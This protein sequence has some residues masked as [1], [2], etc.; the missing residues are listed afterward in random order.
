MNTAPQSVNGK[1][2]F[3]CCFFGSDSICTEATKTQQRQL[4]QS[5]SPLIK[6]ETPP[7]EDI[8]ARMISNIGRFSK[9]KFY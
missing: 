8:R 7:I 6:C 1:E 9:N 4:D 2:D 3:K 5:F